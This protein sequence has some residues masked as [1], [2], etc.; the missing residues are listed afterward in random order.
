VPVEYA[1]G[2][3]YNPAEQRKRIP[4]VMTVHGR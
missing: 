3:L 4:V 2:E 1:A